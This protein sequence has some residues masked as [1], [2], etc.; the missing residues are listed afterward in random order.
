M[1]A[2]LSCVAIPAAIYAAAFAAAQGGAAPA[3]ALRFVWADGSSLDMPGKTYVWCG[4]WDDGTNIRTLRIQQGSPLSPPWWFLEVRV[5]LGNRGHTIPFP[6]LVGRT[7]TM[8]V[9]YP[10]RQLEVS[11]D[12]ER[13]RGAVTILENVSCRPG[14]RVRFGVRARLASEEAGGPSIDVRGTF[15]GSV[16][17]TAAPGVQP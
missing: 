11:A 16:G 17:K 8:F 15:V 2:P 1:R 3:S 13:S 14:S 7:G 5:T 6:T 10:R 4:R 12:S 9:A